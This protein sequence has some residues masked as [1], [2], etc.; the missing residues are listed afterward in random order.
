[1]RRIALLPLSVLACAGFLRA[2]RDV[3]FRTDVS[4]IRVDAQ[5]LDRNNKPITGLSL[6]DFVL[7]EQGREQPIRSFSAEE[8]PIDVVLLI[9]V[10]GSMEPHVQR[11]ADASAEAMKVLGPD[12]RVA[13]MVFDRRTRLRLRLRKVRDNFQRDLYDVIER[14]SFDGGTDI[15]R[16]LLD[17]ADYLRSDARP[18]ARR[19]T[20]ILTDDQTERSRDERGVLRA[21]TRADAVLCALITPDAMMGR[22]SR[23]GG[24]YPNDPLGGII[25]GRRGPWGG[26]SPGP[27]IVRGGTHSAGTEEIARE[28]GG[29]SLRVDDA[30]ALE[31]TL[32]RLR[33]R[34]AIYFNLPSDVQPGQERNIEVQLSDAARRR[35]RGAEVRF[36]R[37]YLAPDSVTAPSTEVISQSP[38]VEGDHEQVTQTN[39]RHRRPPRPEVEIMKVPPEASVPS[40][41]SE[42]A[43]TGEPRACGD[44]WRRV[45]EPACIPPEVPKPAKK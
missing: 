14:E 28:S 10:S 2:Q 1:L 3:V 42:P 26:R 7:F 20:V 35:Y 41:S 15:T 11:L 22:R 33:Q 6:E 21:L 18:E 9:D 29:D 25:F 5:V 24:A 32:A 36:R 45:D 17:A 27:V 43:K 37:V 34:Y 19:A 38:A 8:T 40:R 30:S 39:P 31:T 23:A 44:G 4:Q 16:A 13:V 12:D